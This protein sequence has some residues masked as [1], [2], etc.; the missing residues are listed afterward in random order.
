MHTLRYGGGIKVNV[1]GETPVLCSSEGQE[2][3]YLDT[4]PRDFESPAQS[5]SITS[6]AN[7]VIVLHVVRMKCG[8]IGYI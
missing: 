8:G 4:F 5:Q 7:E 1:E 3:L 6:S 2:Y